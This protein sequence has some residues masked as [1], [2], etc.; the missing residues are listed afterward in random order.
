MAIGNGSA[1]LD[2]IE[3]LLR[4]NRPDYAAPPEESV[5]EE[6]ED[7]KDDVKEQAQSESRRL[8]YVD[9]IET[10]DTTVSVEMTPGGTSMST[11][12]VANSESVDMNIPKYP[13]KQVVKA[14][15]AKAKSTDV[16]YIRDM[17]KSLVAEARKIFPTA[18]NNTD[19]LAAYVALKS[20]NIDGLTEDQF[21]L[22]HNVKE[23]DP[24]Q[25]MNAHLARLDKEMSRLF[26]NT[27]QLELAVAYLIFDRLGY[28]QDN[29]SGPNDTNLLEPGVEE[30]IERIR[31]QSDQYA[32]QENIRR[33]RPI[34]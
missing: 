23:K 5:V 10:T 14:P 28:R 4:N 19:A 12:E 18:S 8:P 13:G 30:L 2:A 15:K 22:V 11:V 1:N 27:Q 34:R 16:T 32:K 9:D 26:G 24:V 6:N 17:P 20:G 7:A 31:V 25:V 33:G 3:A 29:P 21:A